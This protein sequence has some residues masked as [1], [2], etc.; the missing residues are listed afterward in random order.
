M[1]GFKLPLFMIFGRRPVKFISTPEGGMDIL[2]FDWESGEFERDLS[3]LSKLF[4]YSPECDEVTEEEFDMYVKKLI[5]QI[6]KR[7]K[8]R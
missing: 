4:K 2:A 8:A 7:E 6:S 5:S 3:Y 1:T